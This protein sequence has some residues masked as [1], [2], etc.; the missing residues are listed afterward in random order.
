MTLLSVN[1]LYLHYITEN[2]IVV[3][4]DGVSF[5]ITQGEALG[6]VGESGS[7][8]TSMSLA[9][10][11]LI[12]R[13]A[14]NYT[15]TVAF[16][17]KQIMQMS[18]EDFRNSIRWK[19]IAMVFQGAMNSLNPVLRVEQQIS[20]PMKFHGDYTKKEINNRVLELL[21]MVNLPH[22]VAKRYPHE[23]SGGMK[24]RVLIAM[25]LVL[26]PSLIILDEPTSA[27]DV[28][29]QAQI[30]NLLKTLKKDLGISFIFITHDIALASDISD[31]VA[32]MYAGEIVE[33]GTSEQIFNDPKH[34]YTNKLL[35]SLPNLQ[36]ADKPTFIP[37][38]PPDMTSPPNGCRFHPRCD[39]ALEK[40][41]ATP[42]NYFPL[43]NGQVVHCWLSESL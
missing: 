23:L 40:C 20:E 37:G 10:M 17:D 15:G 21:E 31:K 16:E 25:S 42:P 41:S 13:N 11:R 14:I 3:A 18:D 33:I 4:V 43:P 32:V 36:S 38:A 27:L 19:K 35:K 2:G 5:D 28:S 8:K 29:I 6:I 30:M 26:N 9:L 39:K 22:E 7:G 34:P 1:D 24:Q 12:P